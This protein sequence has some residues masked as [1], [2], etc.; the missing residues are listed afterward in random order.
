VAF[1]NAPPTIE[2]VEDQ[3]ISTVHQLWM[4]LSLQSIRASEGLFQPR[5][6]SRTKAGELG[7][8]DVAIIRKK[9]SPIAEVD[10]SI[11]NA[12]ERVSSKSGRYFN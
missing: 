7:F 3:P 1:T 4:H 12:L 8:C 9:C 2:N 10:T 11:V 6:K 5:L